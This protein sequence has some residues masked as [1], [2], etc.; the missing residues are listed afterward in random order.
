MRLRRTATAPEP[1]AETE[2]IDLRERLA[3][4]GHADRLR[5][6]WRESLIIEDIKRRNRR[7]RVDQWGYRR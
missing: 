7:P 1:D 2:I 4:Y 3:P 6:E 5:P